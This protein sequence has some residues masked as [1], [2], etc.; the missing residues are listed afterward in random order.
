MSWNAAE[1]GEDE[2]YGDSGYLG[3]EKRGDAIIRNKAD[4]KV[5][6]R[7]NRRPSQV[8][9]LSTSLVVGAALSV[10]SST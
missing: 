4:R 2:A 8:K 7:I 9:K 1:R 6:Y 10:V 5:K 3:A